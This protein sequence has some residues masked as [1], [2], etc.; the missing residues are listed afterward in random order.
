MNALPIGT[1]VI[2]CCGMM[3]PMPPGWI[4]ITASPRCA[5][6]IAVTVAQLPEH[7]I[8]LTVARCLLKVAES[9]VS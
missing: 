1:I 3:N 9:P 7:K 4:D 6:H 5:R 8:D 2:L